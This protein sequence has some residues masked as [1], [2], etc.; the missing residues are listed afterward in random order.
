MLLNYIITYAGGTVVQS[1]YVIEM[2]SLGWVKHGL[3]RQLEAPKGKS[4]LP[5]AQRVTLGLL[6][7]WPYP[8]ACCEE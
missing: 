4:T 8:V 7:P 2:K 5:P 6:H 3:R 1:R